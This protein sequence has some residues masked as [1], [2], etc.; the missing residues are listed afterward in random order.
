LTTIKKTNNQT[1]IESIINSDNSDEEIADRFSI[2]DTNFKKFVLKNGI[3]TAMLITAIGLFVGIPAVYWFIHSTVI[4]IGSIFLMLFVCGSLGLVQWYYLKDYLDMAYHQFSMYAFAGF[5]LCVL[6]IILFLNYTIHIGKY[7]E[8]YEI[9][10]CYL[11]NGS[12]EVQL[13]NSNEVVLAVEN[14]VGYYL[15]E[16]YEQIPSTKNI[17]VKFEKGLFGFDIIEEI[18]FN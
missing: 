12:Y 16:H 10:N 11:K 7:T 2:E 4:S 18:K 8:N 6:T 14:A 3:H 1:S 17:S 13:S 9:I 5:G 15:I